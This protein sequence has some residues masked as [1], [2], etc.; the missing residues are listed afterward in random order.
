[1]E[2]IDRIWLYTVLCL[3]VDARRADYVRRLF[4][5]DWLDP[6][7]YDLIIDTRAFSFEAAADLIQLAL[8]RKPATPSAA[9]PRPSI[10]T[11]P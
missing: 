2:G 9:D 3:T 7:H 4:G 10:G 6:L 11:T 5:V 8:S 1:M